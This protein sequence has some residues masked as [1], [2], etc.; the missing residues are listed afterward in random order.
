MSIAGR[1]VG[2]HSAQSLG[3]EIG[4]PV[5]K[6]QRRELDNAIGP[7]PRARSAA[8]GPTQLAAL[9]LGTT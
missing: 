8:A 7:R 3:H 6:L 5:Q 2:K 4:E 1:A 9:C